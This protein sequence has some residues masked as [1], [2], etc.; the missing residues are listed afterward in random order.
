LSCGDGALGSLGA[1]LVAWQPPLTSI[2]QPLALASS[3]WLQLYSCTT[4]RSVRGSG[5]RDPSIDL[6]MRA[7]ERS[8]DAAACWGSAA[9]AGAA[10][11]WRA[12][13]RR[14]AAVR[15]VGSR[16]QSARRPRMR[17]AAAAAACLAFWLPLPLPPPLLGR[18]RAVA[19]RPR[20]SL[21]W[22]WAAPRGSRR[23]LQGGHR[24][25]S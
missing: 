18:S 17:H 3:F 22:A 7:C 1:T 9:G 8:A 5:S 10:G 16:V 23:A 15:L 24:G 19:A 11:C 6:S 25:G 13:A 12:A 20:S 2:W 21:Y 4:V 14:A